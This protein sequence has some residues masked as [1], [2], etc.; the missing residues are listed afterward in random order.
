MMESH[1][2]LEVF[3]LR[4]GK[5]LDYEYNEVILSSSVSST[6]TD[7]AISGFFR[8]VVPEEGSERGWPFA[9]Y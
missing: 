1:E 4:L 8:R 6:V 3:R 2:D 9:R 7:E 5:A